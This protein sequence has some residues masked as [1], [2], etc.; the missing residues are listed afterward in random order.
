MLIRTELMLRLQS[1][2]E[3]MFVYEYLFMGRIPS[4]IRINDTKPDDVSVE[5]MT[6][7]PSWELIKRFTSVIEAKSFIEEWVK[8]HG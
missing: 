1:V 7:V 4:H 6:S 3:G 5:V 2:S 8:K